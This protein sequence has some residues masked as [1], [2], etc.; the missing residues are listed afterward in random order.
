VG[1]QHLIDEEA[2]DNLVAAPEVIPSGYDAMTASGEPMPNFLAAL[3]RTRSR[4]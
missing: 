4:R 3:H 2:L 1:T